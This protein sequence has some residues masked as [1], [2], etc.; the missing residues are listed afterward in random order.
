QR[1]L[2]LH[3]LHDG[4]DVALRDLVAGRDA[5]GHHHGRGR[6]ADQPGLAAG[7]PVYR[8]V[9]LDEVVRA[10]RDREYVEGPAADAQPELEPSRP[11]DI[12]LDRTAVKIHLVAA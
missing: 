10:L 5:D 3:A 8:A 6:G 1:R 11:L 4:H 9:D 12:H 2:H 7:D